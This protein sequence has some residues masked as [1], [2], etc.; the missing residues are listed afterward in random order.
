VFVLRGL[1][2][3]LRAVFGADASPYTE[4]PAQPPR[5]QPPLW[6]APQGPSAQNEHPD[7]EAGDQIAYPCAW[8]GPTSKRSMIGS[9]TSPS[10]VDDTMPP[11]TTVAS[12]R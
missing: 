6:P 8:R 4:G 7:P 10:S 12:G 11:M 1:V 3:A 9:T 2:R 5:P